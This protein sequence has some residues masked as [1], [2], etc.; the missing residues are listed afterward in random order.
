M[1]RPEHRG[2]LVPAPSIEDTAAYALDLLSALIRIDS[3]NTGEDETTVGE[4]TSAE[5]VATALSD[6]GYEVSYVDAGNDRHSVVARLEGADRE[7]G[8]LLV[9]AHLD[10]VPADPFDWTIH[11][12]SGEIHDGYV[13]GRG[14]VDMK[15]MV[16][17]ALSL[18]VRYKR[19]NIVPARDIVFAFVADEEAGGRLGAGYLVRTRPELLDG[20]T[21]AIGEVGGFSHTLDNGIR[22][23]LIQ[24]AEKSKRWLK[25]RARGV[26]GHGS[27]IVEDNPIERLSEALTILGRHRFPVTITPT[28]REFL[29][30]ISQAGGWAFAHDEDAEDVVDRLGGL[31][32]IIGATI[33]DT[34]NVTMVNAGYK[35][36]VIP[37]VAEAEVDCRLLPGRREAFDAELATLLGPKIE[38]EWHEQDSV[39]TTF[40]GGLVDTMVA[41]LLKHDPG[42]IALPY[43][44]SGGTDAKRFAQLDIRHF[45]FTP[46]LLPPDLDFAAL[47]HGVDER[48]PVDS[49]RFGVRVLDEFLRQA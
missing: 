33:R 25:I 9:H 31:S 4:R 49:I 47:F 13:W 7:R 6:A 23:Y 3:T 27:M 29:H 1:P 28:V 5:F 26:A 44:M 21:E 30:G 36:N 35:S 48:V 37:A 11:P 15:H 2:D 32:R 42:A 18:A 22:A 34:A 41:A 38:L 24:T 12:L 43:M 10:V 8:G 17:M 46:L 45:G 40:D 14:A 16:A 19:H 39:V 20:V